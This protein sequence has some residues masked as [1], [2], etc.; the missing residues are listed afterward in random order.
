MTWCDVASSSKTES[1][2]WCINSKLLQWECMIQKW[3]ISHYTAFVR[4]IPQGELS[5]AF[6]HK[7]R[8]VLAYLQAPVGPFV[9]FIIT[10]VCMRS[11]FYCGSSE[12]V[13]CLQQVYSDF[14]LTVWN[15]RGV[16]SWWGNSSHKACS[17]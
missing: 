16:A 2:W 3:A 10:G 12:C 9:T 1:Y 11:V 14:W 5:C 7:V 8:H 17:V 4:N 13:H 15:G 6:A